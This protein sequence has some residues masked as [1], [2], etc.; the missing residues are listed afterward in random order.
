[1]AQIDIEKFR[2]IEEERNTIH[3]KVSATYTVFNA[4]GE[5]F[6]KIDTYG[7]SNRDMPEKISQSLQLDRKTAKHLLNLIKNTFDLE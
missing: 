5:K 2:R 4:Y 6:F 3:T 7:N 1:M